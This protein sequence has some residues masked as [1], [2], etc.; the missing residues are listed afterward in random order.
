[1]QTYS[2]IRLLRCCK[3]GLKK[4]MPPSDYKPKTETICP[5]CQEE[6][7]TQAHKRIADQQGITLEQLYLNMKLRRQQLGMPDTTFRP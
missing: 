5:A 7:D 2:E 4:L 6:L 3:C 1:M